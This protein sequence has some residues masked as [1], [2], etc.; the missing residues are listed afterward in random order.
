MSDSPHRADRR[1][2]L[3][4]I[5]RNYLRSRVLTAAAR[6]GVADALA[7]G[8]GR[9]EELAEACQARP[10]SLR[11]L[12]RAL[13]TIGIVVETQP[14]R[15]VLTELGRGLCKS[16]PD[17]GWAE[18]VFWGDLLAENWAY[19]TECV[20]TGAN[21]WEVAQPQGGARWSRDPEEG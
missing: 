13:A 6:L 2:A 5:T 16:A 18:V 10:D 15:F 11:R 20:R 12:L 19:L 3:L 8:E 17:S 21:A 7:D 1:R 4:Q 9:L 14:D